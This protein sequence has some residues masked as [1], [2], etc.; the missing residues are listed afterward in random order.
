MGEI[1]TQK[2]IMDMF[3]RATQVLKARRQ[4]GLLTVTDDQLSECID[5]VTVIRHFF[6]V[7]GEET[8]VKGLTLELEHLRSI[9]YYRDMDKNR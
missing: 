2:F 3:D 7:M 5:V 9:R 6:T 4:T 1:S 8:V